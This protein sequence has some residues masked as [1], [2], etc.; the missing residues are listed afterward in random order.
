MRIAAGIEYDGSHYHGWQKQN[1][2]DTIQAHVEQALSHVANEPVNIVCAG[3]TDVGV[4]ATCQVIHFDTQAERSEISWIL[5]GN[6]FLPK[7]IR[8]HW[9][10]HVP[11]EF[12]ARFS[13]HSRRYQYY[14]VN[15]PT[16]SALLVN[17]CSWIP[18]PLDEKLMQQAGNDLLGEHDFSSYR[19]TEC[20]SKTP[21]R[22]VMALSIKRRDEIIL[23][24]I[25]ANAFLHH[26]V[27]NIAGVLMTIGAGKESVCWAKAVLE[28]KDRRHAGVTARPQGLYLVEVEYP[29]EFNLCNLLKERARLTKHGILVVK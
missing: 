28:A 9:A 11:D 7:D 1:G 25:K 27:R 10:K 8:I 21:N 14:I 13:A 22:N 19:A 24:D 15:M 20:Q 3:R 17:Y 2:L 16:H 29:G 23:I 4:H 6:S 18:K 12:H 26:M 5:G